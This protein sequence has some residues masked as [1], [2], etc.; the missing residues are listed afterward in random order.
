MLVLVLGLR[1][2][3]TISNTSGY[4]QHPQGVASG[5]SGSRSNRPHGGCWHH[6]PMM[7][8]NIVPGRRSGFLRLPHFHTGLETFIGWRLRSVPLILITLVFKQI[9]SIP[10]PHEILSGIS[11]G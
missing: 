5:R 6:A 11:P 3:T 2:R 7:S 1:S 8:Q 9:F 4:W 10:F